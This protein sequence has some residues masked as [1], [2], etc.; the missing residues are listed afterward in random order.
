MLPDPTE[1]ER[2]LAR[3]GLAVGP[4]VAVQVQRYLEILQKWNQRFNLTGYR[5]PEEQ[6][7]SLFGETF[8]A[9][10]R[11]AEEDSP[12]L[13]VG[14]GAGFPG[15]ALKLV[16]PR[17]HCYLLEP[18]KKRAAFLATVR[19][20]LQLPSVQVF[21]KPLEQCRTGDFAPPPRV[22]TLRALGRTEALITQALGLLSSL[23]RVLLFTTRRSLEGGVPG[24]S[25]I[26]WD[27]PVPIPWS[28][29]KV[30]LLGRVRTVDQEVPCVL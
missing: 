25:R 1:I 2:L 7:V 17:L 13:D 4:E 9:A 12:L 14:S 26:Q 20:E 23:G 15:L 22:M 21:S 10:G 18:R 30:M 8:L 11:L 16:R 24:S 29:Q 3:C 6:I 19:R 28:H 27:A 5:E